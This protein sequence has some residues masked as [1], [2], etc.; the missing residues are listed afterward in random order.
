MDNDDMR[1]EHY[2][3]I[4]AV[5]I[6]GVNEDGEIIFAINE[7]AKDIAPELWQ[8]HTDY[9]D[10]TLIDL[11]E[12]GYVKVEYDENL[13]AMISLNQEGFKIAKDLGI[14]PMDMPEIPND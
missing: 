3:E 8:A 11:Y 9:V 2:I 7:I 14:I 12:A 5:E 4:G 13:E 10:K 1:L 6:A